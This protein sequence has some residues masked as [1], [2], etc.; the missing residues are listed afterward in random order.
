MTLGVS[1]PLVWRPFPAFT[2]NVPP[3][4]PATF[5]FRLAVP[6]LPNDAALRRLRCLLTTEGSRVGSVM[7]PGVCPWLWSSH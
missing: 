4:S 6:P 5:H 7:A 1:V 3:V 2:T